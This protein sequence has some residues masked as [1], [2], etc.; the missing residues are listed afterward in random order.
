MRSTDEGD[1]PVRAKAALVDPA[2]MTVRWTNDPDTCPGPGDP[3]PPI[4]EAVP[5]AE[6]LGVPEALA[7]VARTGVARHLQADVI[8]THKGSMALVASVYR[9]PDGMLLVVSE[10]TW[11][12]AKG[13]ADASGT[14]RPG[15]RSR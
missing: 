11:Q 9:L 8:T 10:H 6:A 1:A 4:A 14:R 13:R 7:D 3:A 15:R 12:P 5:M 2:S